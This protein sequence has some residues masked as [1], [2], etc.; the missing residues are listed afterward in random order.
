MSTDLRQALQNISTHDGMDRLSPGL[1][2]KIRLYAPERV[3]CSYSGNPWGTRICNFSNGCTACLALERAAY[4]EATGDKP[5]E[6]GQPIPPILDKE[7]RHKII[8]A[9]SQI[10]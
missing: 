1:Q 9:L 8:L 10:E 7:L 4:F 3:N 2:E 5:W 6:H